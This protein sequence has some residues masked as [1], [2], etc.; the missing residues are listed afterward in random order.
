MQHVV[1]LGDS[2]FDN[3]SYVPGKPPVIEQLQKKLLPNWKATLLAVDGHVTQDVLSQTS[4]LPEDASHLIISCGGNDALGHSGLL[5]DSASSV[6]DVLQLFGNI[7][8]NFQNEYKKMLDHVLSLNIPTAVC[9]IYDTIPGYPIAAMTALS[10]FNE[11]I[12]REAF[13]KRIPVLDFRLLFNDSGDYSNI[14]PIEPSAAGGEKIV[15]A[16]N[17]LL[18]NHD[19]SVKRSTVY[20]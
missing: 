16:I 7:R 8:V 5:L 9:T 4:F 18:A 11:I 6:T 10:F 1:L 2:I 17:Q 20:Y 3:A 19:F 13:A 12:L 14:S 15:K